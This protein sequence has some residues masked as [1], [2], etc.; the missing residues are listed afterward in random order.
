MAAFSPSATMFLYGVSGSSCAVACE[1][2]EVQI[3]LATR[4]RRRRR[5]APRGG[6]RAA[7]RLASSMAAISYG[8]LCTRSWSSAFISAGGLAS[9]MPQWS[10]RRVSSPTKASLPDGCRCARASAA[11]S[12]T[13]MSNCASQKSLSGAGGFSQKFGGCVQISLGRCAGADQQRAVGLRQRQP[14]LELRR[15]AQ[16]PDTDRRTRCAPWARPSG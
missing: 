7:M 4:R 5:R 10:A 13:T 2:R 14:V 15:R 3:E 6:R 9:P 11:S 1:I 8:V 16:R 12:M